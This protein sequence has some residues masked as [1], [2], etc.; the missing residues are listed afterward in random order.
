MAVFLV[1]SSEPLA[2]A[3]GGGGVRE[4][5]WDDS[6]AVAPNLLAVQHRG[7]AEEVCDAVR[8]RLA[9]DVS[10]LV[11]PVG[12][13]PAGRGVPDDLTAWLNGHVAGNVAR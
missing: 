7:T 10:V 6:R 8:S 4:P 12:G 9:D 1:W 5:A 13:P 3:D 2:P 11:S